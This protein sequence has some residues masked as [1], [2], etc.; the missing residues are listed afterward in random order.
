MK[1]IVP[2]FVLALAAAPIAVADE[3]M[4]ANGIRWACT[5]I[6]ES[7]EDPRWADFPLKLVFATAERRYLSD[8][9]VVIADRDRARVFEAR[10]EVEPWL[11]IDLPPGD[12]FATARALD[13][14]QK[15]YRITVP[16]GGQQ[17]YDFRFQKIAEP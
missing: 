4:E 7:R 9:Q 5:G 14:Q 6:A 15:T 2:Y 11:L 1:R 3:V 8:V 13:Q 12:Y 17:Q 10:C 16:A